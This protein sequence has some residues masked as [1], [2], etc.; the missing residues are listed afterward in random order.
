MAASC[1]AGFSPATFPRRA[2]PEDAAGLKRAEAPPARPPQSA[3]IRTRLADP[4]VETVPVSRLLTL[5]ETFEM[6]PGIG[7]A[8]GELDQKEIWSIYQ[9]LRGFAKSSR[10]AGL[11]ELEQ[12]VNRFERSVDRW[13]EQIDLANTPD[14]TRLDRIVTDLRAVARDM[15]ARLGEGKD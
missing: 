14:G 1:P 10:P 15:R 11:A 5:Q 8:D 3:P 4:L 9:G 2:H 7:G 13:S 12:S 6:N